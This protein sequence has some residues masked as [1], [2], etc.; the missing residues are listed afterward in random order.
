MMKEQIMTIH[1]QT[2]DYLDSLEIE[3]IKEISSQVTRLLPWLKFLEFQW[4]ITYD[5]SI[6][7]LKP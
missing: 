3:Q 4:Q 7:S 6:P 5:E 1:T 2:N